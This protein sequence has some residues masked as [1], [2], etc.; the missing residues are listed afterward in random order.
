MDSKRS[1]APGGIGMQRPIQEERPR[2]SNKKAHS[3]NRSGLECGGDISPSKLLRT[4]PSNP[5]ALLHQKVH[6]RPDL[7]WHLGPRGHIE[8]K[9]REGGAPGGEYPYQ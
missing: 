6:Q 8:I 4:L 3:L 2:Q 1:Q 7:G 9:P 5:F